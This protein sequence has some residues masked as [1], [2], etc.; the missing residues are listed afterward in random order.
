MPNPGFAALGAS[1]TTESVL[2]RR[3]I[4]SPFPIQTQVIPDALA[5]LDILAKSPTGSGKTLAFGVPMLERL[6]PTPRPGALVLVPTRELASQVVEELSDLAAAYKLRIRPVYGGV[7]LPRQASEASRSHVVVATPGRLEDLANRRLLRLDNVRILVLDEADRML[8][9]GFRPQ[10]DTIVRRLPK[11]RQ[12]MFFSATLDGEVALLAAAYT[13]SP[14]RHQVASAKPTVDRVDHTF[15]RVGSSVEKVSVLVDLLSQERELALV[16]V[17]TKLAAERLARMLRSR[18][19]H[20]V[21]MHGDMTQTAR[22]RSLHQFATGAATTLIATD[23]AARGLDLD[24]ITHVINFDP[25]YDHTSYVHRIGRTARAGG[26]G[27]GI[28]LVTPEQEREMGRVAVQ[29]ELREEF[30]KD[31]LRVPAPALAFS[32]SRGRSGMGRRPRRR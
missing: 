4:T 1:G 6:D 26:A 29:L 12:T 22:E 32:S 19:L 28:T 7:P 31:G 14:V 3:S 13:Q 15:V 8:D 25:P 17:R 30:E 11:E 24:G 9:M 2:A 18:G 27:S 21:A 20:V 5:G 10:V 16:F 23:V